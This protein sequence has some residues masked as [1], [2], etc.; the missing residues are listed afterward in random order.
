M[1]QTGEVTTRLNKFDYSSKFVDRDSEVN[2]ARNHYKKDI[3]IRERFQLW[4]PDF[5]RM[6]L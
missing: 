4:A 6:L 2:A 5:M 1:G 3:A